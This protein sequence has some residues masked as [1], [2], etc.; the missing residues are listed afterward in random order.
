VTQDQTKFNISLTDV[1]AT[2]EGS[3]LVPEQD[4]LE[5][6]RNLKSFTLDIDKLYQGE[7]KKRGRSTNI[8]ITRHYSITNG[9]L[10][11]YSSKE[12]PVPK[13]KSS[14]CV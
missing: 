11:Q 3:L 7:L 6:E 12:D 9:V 4:R 1:K 2:I 13:R 10:C 14:P 5:G 8:W